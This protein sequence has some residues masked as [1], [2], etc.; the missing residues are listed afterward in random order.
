[1][2]ALA[3]LAGTGACSDGP[4]GPVEGVPD[5]EL[6]MAANL[7][8]ANVATL[9]VKVTAPD[10]SNV[11]V[12]NL[13]INEDGFAFGT[14]KVP[15]GNDRL[16]TVQAFDDMGVI[17][18]EGA[19]LVNVQPGSNPPVFIALVPRSGHVPLEIMMGDIVVNISGPNTGTP[20]QV[21]QLQAQIYGP[22]GE[23]T[24]G[25]IAWA[26]ENPAI[27]TVDQNGL[28]NLLLPG[29]V[30]IYALSS[31]YSGYMEITVLPSGTGIVNGVVFD[32][33]TARPVP[34]GDV[35]IDDLYV[36]SV[37]ESGTFSFQYPGGT[38][39]IYVY[40]RTPE[41]IQPAVQEVTI[42]N[43]STTFVYFPVECLA[44]QSNNETDLPEEADYCIVTPPSINALFSE[45]VFIYG[46]VFEAGWTEGA[47][48]IPAILAKIGLGPAMT[49]P[50]AD[51]T[52]RWFDAAFHV[53][54]GNSDEY[55]ISLPAEAFLG[56]HAYAFRVS[57]N[58]GMSW[59]YCDADGAGSNE[60]QD[61]SAGAVGTLQVN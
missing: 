38:Y 34:G 6:V 39:P 26:S 56:L 43:G 13:E 53:D 1:V 7:A 28:V 17:T 9:V 11:L 54:V 36:T 10:L 5:A 25:E 16:I 35:I 46:Q 19:A 61:F 44:A 50:T 20:G 29:T 31:G 27:A 41:C 32:A 55:W 4:A 22:L 48:E 33:L 24:G 57:R 37:D 47:G 58:G 59:T 18:H 49:D 52:W 23:V 40:L 15:P 45:V 30:R 21:L 12:F 3:V 14:I 8:G 60:G 2:L 51:A 42:T